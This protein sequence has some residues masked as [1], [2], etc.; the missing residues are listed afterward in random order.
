MYIP[1]FIASARRKILYEVAN[2]PTARDLA[3]R[4]WP[5]RDLVQTKT[6]ESE[7]CV[8]ERERERMNFATIAAVVVVVVVSK[9]RRLEGERD[10]FGRQLTSLAHQVNLPC[11][12]VVVSNVDYISNYSSPAC[13]SSPIPLSTFHRAHRSV[14]VTMSLAAHQQVSCAAARAVSRVWLIEHRPSKGTDFGRTEP[15]AQC[16]PVRL[17]RQGIRDGGWLKQFTI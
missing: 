12:I 7:I 9:V 15:S 11:Y 3:R 6:G 10:Q 14:Q 8:C 5:V 2:Q 17:Q 4:G 16:G 1:P 13:H